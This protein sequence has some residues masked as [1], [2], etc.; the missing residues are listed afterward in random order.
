[1]P[2]MMFYNPAN[3]KQQYWTI[4]ATDANIPVGWVDSQG[5]DGAQPAAVQVYQAG[6]N[7]Q[8]AGAINYLANVDGDP[9]QRVDQ[10]DWPNGILNG[11]GGGKAKQPTKWP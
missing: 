11:Y 5:S 1:M 6:V 8:G 3:P 2:R 4:S 10:P 7:N 9:Q